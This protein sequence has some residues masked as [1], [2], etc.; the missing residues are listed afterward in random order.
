MHRGL[1]NAT[2]NAAAL[3]GV[4]RRGW[5]H[6]V[7][8]REQGVASVSAPVRSPS[9]K[10]I[11]AVSVSGPIERLSRQPGR[12]HAPAVMAAAER[13]SEASAA[14]PSSQGNCGQRPQLTRTAVDQGGV[15]GGRFQREYVVH[16]GREEREADQRDPRSDGAMR[17]PASGFVVPVQVGS[18]VVERGNC[19]LL[20][21][22]YFGV[23][24]P[25]Q[26]RLDRDG[27]FPGHRSTG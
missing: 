20:T 9:G 17:D 27:T 26:A 14:P 4:R 3:A 10:V 15:V 19:S 11:A 5:A 13:L 6:S 2:F 1:H 25:E 12:M 18:G 24:T 21:L 23:D 22:E 16:G 7:G 8:E